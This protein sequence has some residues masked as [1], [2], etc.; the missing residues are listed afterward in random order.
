MNINRFRSEGLVF[1][2]ARA[3]NFVIT[4]TFPDLV[5]IPNLP[6]KC[7]LLGR[8]S[9]LPESAIAEIPVPYFGRNIKVAGNRQFDDWE[10]TFMND[11]DF[12]IKNAFEAW[13]NG[14]NTIIS[15]RL[16]PRMANISPALGNSYKT[17]A[18]VTQISKE[19]PGTIDSDGAIKT[20][21]FE[22]IFPV[23]V[24]DIPLDFDAVNQIEQFQVRFAYDWYEPSRRS[25]DQPLFPLELSDG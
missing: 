21:K 3:S 12:L 25:G 22:G 17:T 5:A 10:V 1:G 15:N 2:G 14:V 7:Q 4:L 23:L 11:E 13:H 6:A 19:G 9:K 18:E 8:A 24:S 20:Y 16:D